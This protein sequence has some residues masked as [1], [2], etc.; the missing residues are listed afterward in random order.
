MLISRSWMA[1]VGLGAIAAGCAQS[2]TA[3]RPDVTPYRVQE[4]TPDWRSGGWAEP[5]PRFDDRPVTAPRRTTGGWGQHYPWR[6][7]GERPSWY[8]VHPHVRDSFVLIGR[9][10]YPYYFEG[11]Q[12]YPVYSMPHTM[13]G[14]GVTPDYGPLP[15]FGP[16]VVAP[17]SAQLFRRPR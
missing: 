3:S 13:S 4:V 6:G 17:A 11:G 8:G 14:H 15:A 12:I 9:Y 10:Y 2:P 7:P 1:L 5:I 16:Y